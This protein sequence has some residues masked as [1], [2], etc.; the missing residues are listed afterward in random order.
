MAICGS[1][2]KRL[3]AV[4]VTAAVAG[5]FLSS[6]LLFCGLLRGSSWC[7]W[8]PHFSLN[9]I[10]ALIRSL[11]FWGIGVSVGLMVIHSFVPFP[12]EFVAVANGMIYGPL[13]GTA[14]TW[15]G[16]MIGAFSAFGLVRLLGRPFVERMLSVRDKS[17]L[18]DWTARYGGEMIL[19]S[20]FIPVISFNL[21]N[22]V[23]GLTR[24]SWWTFAWTTGLGILP[25]TL[26]M[27]IMGEQIKHL[28]WWVWLLLLVIGMG[29]LWLVQRS[30]H[31]KNISQDRRR[32]PDDKSKRSSRT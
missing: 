14:V 28:P 19:I 1:F 5:L 29:M 11:G 6:T 3:F 26:L 30:L 17:K 10:I 16:A 18:D 27:V 13:W 32:L 23:A 21:I 15:T 4:I 7:R 25:M 24:I 8:W 2:K 22:Y 12:A 20:R 9:E 31:S